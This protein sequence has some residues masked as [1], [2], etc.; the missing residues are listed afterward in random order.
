M[1]SLASMPTFFPWSPLEHR[2]NTFDHLGRTMTF[3]D[4]AIEAL[5]HL[6]KIRWL[7][8]QPPRSCIAVA[9]DGT[10]RLLDFVGY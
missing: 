5:L 4:H 2:P 9:Y 10:Q 3:D 7:F 6:L 1:R 8:C